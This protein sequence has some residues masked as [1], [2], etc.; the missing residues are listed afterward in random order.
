M[1]SKLRLHYTPDYDRRYAPIQA[2]K[3]KTWWDDNNRTRDHAKHCL[4]L[5]MANSLG[6]YILSPATFLVR[7]NGDFNKP[8]DIEIGERCS[9]CVVDNH[10]AFGAFVVQPKFVPVTLRPGDFVF[11]K[12][13]PNE[14]GLPY[15]CMEA[16]IEAWWSV[17][18]FGLVYLL[19]QPGEFIVNLGQPI[20]QMFVLAGGPAAAEVEHV[21]QLPPGHAEWQARRSR[22]GYIKDLD[23][24]KGVTASGMH[25]ETHITGWAQ[26]REKFG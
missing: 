19:N 2:V 26:A 7:W 21:S 16:C 13:M 6:W 9:H 15:S 14:R 22:P 24:V 8:A 1:A 23:Y 12:G 18:H 5:N 10:A 4:P 11:I 25:V 17:G 3:L 20:A